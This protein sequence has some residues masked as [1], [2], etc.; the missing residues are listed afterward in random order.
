MACLVTKA[1]RHILPE[2]QTIMC[3]NCAINL[4]FIETC[5]GFIARQG[6]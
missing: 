2:R 4:D 1:I 3:T 6:I 5:T